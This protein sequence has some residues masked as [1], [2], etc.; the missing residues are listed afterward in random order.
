MRT[1]VNGPGTPTTVP[2][3]SQMATRILTTTSFRTQCQKVAKALAHALGLQF[4]LPNHSP[5]RLKQPAKLSLVAALEQLLHS[6]MAWSAG[7]KMNATLSMVVAQQLIS[8]V[9]R[10]ILRTLSRVP[11][12]I[13]IISA[14]G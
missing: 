1:V 4:L 6:P 8:A 11:V 2:V 12:V 14:N 5:L 9:H 3:Q 13:C 7:R 10:R